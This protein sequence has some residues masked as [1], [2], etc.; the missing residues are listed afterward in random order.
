MLL[1]AL[2]LEAYGSCNLTDPTPSRLF[3]PRPT[4]EPFKV[5]VTVSTE[6][7]GAKRKHACRSPALRLGLFERNVTAAL[8]KGNLEAILNLRKGVVSPL[9]PEDV[10][11]EHLIRLG[12]C[13]NSCSDSIDFQSCRPISRL[14][15]RRCCCAQRWSGGG[16]FPSDA[17]IRRPVRRS[18][19]QLDMER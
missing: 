3:H 5:M 2:A 15:Y 12:C 9:T 8:R 7:E 4:R 14:A 18:R 13:L 19:V 6:T 16:P 17:A 1:L 11:F 10:T